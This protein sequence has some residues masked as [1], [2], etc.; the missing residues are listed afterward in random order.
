MNVTDLFLASVRYIR[1]SSQSESGQAALAALSGRLSH[2]WLSSDGQA[3]GQAD[4]SDLVLAGEG[5]NP[6]GSCPG[7]VVLHWP[8]DRKLLGS[9]LEDKY[10]FFEFIFLNVVHWRDDSP[11]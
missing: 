9:A 3:K 4:C 2:R 5:N 6:V 7:R 11:L 8:G 10:D 1:P